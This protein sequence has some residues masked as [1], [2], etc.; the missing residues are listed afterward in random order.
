[1]TKNVHWLRD[2]NMLQKVVP[3]A[4]ISVYGYRSQWYG[5]DAVQEG[6]ISPIA[7]DLLHHIHLDRQG[8]SVMSA[9][10]LDMLL[11]VL[12][13]KQQATYYLYWPQSRRSSCRE[14]KPS[15]PYSDVLLIQHRPSQRPS[16]D[17][18]TIL[19]SSAALLHVSSSGPHSEVQTLRSLHALLAWRGT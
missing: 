16:D 11:I 10:E 13:E 2:E 17:Q 4:R 18:K 1:M 6:G 5:P 15:R 12:V 9:P 19:G 3:D 14:G 8:V 7:N